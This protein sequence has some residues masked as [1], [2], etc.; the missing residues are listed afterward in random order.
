M[1]GA[2]I[3]ANNIARYGAGVY[4][5]GGTSVMINGSISGNIGDYGDAMY[6]GLKGSFKQLG[7][8]IQGALENTS[9]IDAADAATT[10]GSGGSS[11]YV[12]ASGNDANGGT[13]ENSALR[14][15]SKAIELARQSNI[16]VITVI[17][18]LEG[19]TRIEDV[20]ELEILI[21][22]KARASE[23]EKAVFNGPAAEAA[24]DI[25]G[26]SKIRVEYITVSA[27]VGGAFRIRDSEASLTLGT[28][29]RI[30]GRSETLTVGV[31]L[32]ND[33]T[34]IMC[35]DA[36]I[37]NINASSSA[38]YVAKG[39]FIMTDNALITQN[40][41]QANGGGVHI[42]DG[43]FTMQGN[44]RISGNRTNANGGGVSIDQ[45]S[46]S[47]Q[48]NALISDNTA[49]GYGGG[50]F[51]NLVGQEPPSFIMRDMALISG[52]T[53]TNLGGGV[54]II[55]E[56][57]L[58]GNARVT[59]NAALSGGG[60][61]ISGNSS[62]SLLENAKITANRASGADNFGGG[63]LGLDKTS[64]ISLSGN[65]V[66]SG[67]IADYGGGAATFGAIVGETNVAITANRALKG[68][69]GVVFLFKGAN[70]LREEDT[71]QI[72]TLF[73]NARGNVAPDSKEADIALRVLN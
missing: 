27:G 40:S 63:I 28:G 68:G 73:E 54:Y 12:S 38:V 20:G 32:E 26:L 47:M 21:T 14:T 61:V 7:G 48:E 1:T 46:F 65:A 19:T 70:D 13:R 30:R 69:G 42:R 35:D 72:M 50:V 56:M 25:S 5:E 71:A 66:L 11:Y 55:G 39:T 60:V 33:A 31:A 43:V 8:S 67:N 22:G 15:L 37:S 49:L 9:V 64:K 51:M 34:L 41:T 36:S 53:A 16:K 2:G 18:T 6:V 44:A 45:G 62:L 17:G 29:T 3:V 58:L 59:D 4:V 23:A 24:F 52:N 10:A 57:I